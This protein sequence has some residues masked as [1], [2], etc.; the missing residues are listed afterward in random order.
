MAAVMRTEEHILD[1]IGEVAVID[2]A[3]IE[4]DLWKKVRNISLSMLEVILQPSMDLA[5]SRLVHA[6]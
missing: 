6:G 2:T 5:R 1:E 4:K 3:D